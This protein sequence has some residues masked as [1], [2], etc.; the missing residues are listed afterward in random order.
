MKNKIK[1][2]SIIL[3]LIILTNSVY[4]TDLRLGISGKRDFKLNSN[5]GSPELKFSSKAPLE[6]INGKVDAKKIQSGFSM[7]PSNAEITSGL[8]SFLVDGME[9]GIKTRDGHLQGKDWLD[10]SKFPNIEF[11]LEKFSSVK[12]ISSESGKSVLEA[13]AVGQYKMRGISKSISIPVKLTYLKE[14]DA[15][16]KRASGDLVFI[17]GKF[18]IAL[19]DFNVKGTKGIVGSKVGE[20]ININFQLF[21]NSGK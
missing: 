2:L 13:Q 7:D 17:D 3:G 11:V 12:V 19:K 5:V 20:V 4:S 16:K 21:Y 14:S 9:T 15:T 10:A 18:D 1:L 8:I 6:D